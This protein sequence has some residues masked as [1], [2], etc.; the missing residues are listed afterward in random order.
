MRVPKSGWLHEARSGKPEETSHHHGPIRNTYVRTHRW[1]KIHRHQDELAVGAKEDKL[2]H[3]LFSTDPHDLGLYGKP[4]ARNA[5][6]WTND[7]RLLLDGPHAEA[8]VIPKPLHSLN[9]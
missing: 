9:Q 1:G 5:Q 7:F 6:I 4:M 3:V 2:A 8:D